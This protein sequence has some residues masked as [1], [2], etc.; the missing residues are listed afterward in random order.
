MGKKQ[1]RTLSLE[2]SCEDSSS[3]HR[4]LEPRSNSALRT[5]TYS[6]RPPNVG[7]TP[8]ITPKFDTSKGSRTVSRVARADEV[9]VSLSGSPVVAAA[10][11]KVPKSQENNAL[12]PLGNGETLNIPLGVDLEPSMEY[13]DEQQREKLGELQKSLASMLKI[14]NQA[15]GL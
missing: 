10:A 14:K 15:S 3:G 5:P 11:N 12:I 7:K 1:A 6:R 9:L 8:L 4:L 2:S 13:L